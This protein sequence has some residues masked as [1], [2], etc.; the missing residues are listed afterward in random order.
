MEVFQD[1]P[2]DTAVFPVQHLRVRRRLIVRTADELPPK[3][4]PADVWPVEAVGHPA[5]SMTFVQKLESGLDGF[6]LTGWPAVAGCLT[7]AGEVRRRVDDLRG[8]MEPN[9]CL[10]EAG[11]NPAPTAPGLGVEV[12]E[13]ALMKLE[14]KVPPTPPLNSCL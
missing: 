6:E 10:M 14:F 13:A 5:D 9:G 7:R 11:S 1:A 3:R 8:Q 4:H 12:D 2:I